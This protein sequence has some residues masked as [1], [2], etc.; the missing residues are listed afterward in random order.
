MVE[1]TGPAKA[2][3][4]RVWPFLLGVV[5]ALGAGGGLLVWQ[6]FGDKPVSVAVETLELAPA[7]RV[8]AVNGQLAALTSVAVRAAVS[9]EALSIHAAEGDRVETGAVLAE[10][11]GTQAQAVVRQA[12]AALESGLL[13]Q[14]QASATYGRSRDLGG[15]VAR[16]KA[17]DDA[18]ALDAAS[19]EVGRLTALLQQAEIQAARYVIKAPIAGTVMQRSVDPGQLVDPATPLFTVADLSTLVVETDVDE[20]FAT[21][22]RPGLPATMQLV[23]TSGTLPGHVS[24]VAPRVDPATGGLAVKIAFDAPLAAPVGL[25]VTANIVV[26]ARDS[27]ITVPRAALVTEGAGW[28]VYVLEGGRLHRRPVTLIDWPAARL[29]VTEGLAPGDVLAVDAAGLTEGQSAKRA[30]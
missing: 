12:R 19:Q 29:I 25:T 7:T 22:I 1:Q 24:F 13:A 30:D 9:A 10:L 4:R 15:N 21:Q 16:T 28:A 2:K 5:V 11:D 14:A 3:P 26:D 27:A 17:E 20:A 18:R 23:G 8:L 6:P